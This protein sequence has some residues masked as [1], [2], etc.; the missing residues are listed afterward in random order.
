MKDELLTARPDYE[1]MY[2]NLCNEHKKL[3]AE[4][5]ELKRDCEALESE[6]ARIRAQLDIVYLIFGK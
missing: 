4:H 6:F 1:A 2:N 5:A 3:C